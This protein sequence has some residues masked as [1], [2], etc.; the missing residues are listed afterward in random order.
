MNSFA[1]LVKL[2]LF[3]ATVFKTMQMNAHTGMLQCRQLIEQV[4]KA[5]MVHRVG[6]IKTNDM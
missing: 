5:A 1:V 6:H 2:G 3:T 4:K